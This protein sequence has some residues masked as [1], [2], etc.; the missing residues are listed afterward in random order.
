[1]SKAKH[2][3]YLIKYLST[4]I[5]EN[6]TLQELN[7]DINFPEKID[8]KEFFETTENLKSLTV[9]FKSWEISDQIFTSLYYEE[10]IPRVTNMLKKNEDMKF[11]KVILFPFLQSEVTYKEAWISMIHQFWETVLLYISI[12]ML[13]YN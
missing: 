3:H 12:I 1:M 2:L 13:C 10:I 5:K 6:N 9:S 8:F 7:V 11:L 4:G